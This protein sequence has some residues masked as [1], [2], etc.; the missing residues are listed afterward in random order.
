MIRLDGGVPGEKAE[1]CDVGEDVGGDQDVVDALGARLAGVTL[2]SRVRER[3]LEVGVS[4][5]FGEFW[6]VGWRISVHAEDRFEAAG[7]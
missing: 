2:K 4:N 5:E 3:I 1:G 7:V 6:I